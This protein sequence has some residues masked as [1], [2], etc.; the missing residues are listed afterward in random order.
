MLEITGLAEST[1]AED[2]QK[3]EVKEKTKS[4]EVREEEDRTNIPLSLIERP[5]FHP[6]EEELKPK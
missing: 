2:D 5:R 3:K 1:I 6:I 4:A